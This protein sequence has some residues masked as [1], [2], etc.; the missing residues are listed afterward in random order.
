MTWDGR[1]QHGR[2]APAGAYV[3]RITAADGTAS[4]V[5]TLVK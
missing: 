4:Q 3:V 1:D 2:F 5:V